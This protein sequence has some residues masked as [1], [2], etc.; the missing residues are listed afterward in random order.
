VGRTHL[1]HKSPRRDDRPSES[2]VAH[3]ATNGFRRRDDSAGGG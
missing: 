3:S 1:W 2:P